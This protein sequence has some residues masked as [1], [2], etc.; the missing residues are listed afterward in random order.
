MEEEGHEMVTSSF[1][2]REVV[3]MMCCQG[4]G[5]RERW[6]RESENESGGVR[7]AIIVKG[8]HS[9]NIVGQYLLTVILPFCTARGYFWKAC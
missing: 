9:G 5:H 8:E 4:V 2:S 6:E 7:V 3:L 1:E